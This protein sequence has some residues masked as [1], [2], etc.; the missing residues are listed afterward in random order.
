MATQKEKS[1]NY[2]QFVRI[3]WA[4]LLWSTLW[5]GRLQS[6]NFFIEKKTL[7]TEKEITEKEKEL[8]AFSDIPWFDKLQYVTN[9][10][11]SAT[12][13]PRSNHIETIMDYLWDLVDVD[14]SD[15]FNVSFSDFELSLEKISLHWHVSS[16]RLLY[17]WSSHVNW[18]KALIE[19]FEELKFLDNM[20]IKEYE[21]SADNTWYDFILNANV[22]NNNGK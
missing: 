22:T 4:I 5:R 9:L 16:L 6:Y 11:N 20:S 2:K 13:M 10:E 8:I 17:K 14:K 3:L 19:K 18:S 12:S 15:T 1:T 7:Q 21:K